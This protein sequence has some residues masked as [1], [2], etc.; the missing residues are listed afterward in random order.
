MAAKLLCKGSGA[1]VNNVYY[2]QTIS[3][4]IQTSLS[5]VYTIDFG[6]FF[7]QMIVVDGIHRK[8]KSGSFY[9]AMR[10]VKCA[11][12]SYG[13]CFEVMKFKYSAQRK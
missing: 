12:P 11:T 9:G 7:G 10:Q 8:P 13:S 2:F 4:K 1:T 6:V 3:Y 5:I